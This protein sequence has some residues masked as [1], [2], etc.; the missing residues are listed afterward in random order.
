MKNEYLEGGK[1]CTAHGVAGALKLEHYCDGP[2]VLAKQK[3]IF[4]KNRDGSYK[5]Y[6]VKSASVS[7]QF[8]LMTLDGISTREAAIALRGV[9]VYLHRSDL[10]LKQGEMFIADMIGLPVVHAE[11]GESLGEISDI[12][13]IAGRRIYTINYRG[14]N[15]LLPHVPDFIKEISDE[16]MRVSPIPGFFDEADEI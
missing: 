7:G 15:V 4:F 14:K 6:A 10:P 2:K 16:G 11:S 3:R 13:E 9:T 1:V 8:V 5:E 12:S